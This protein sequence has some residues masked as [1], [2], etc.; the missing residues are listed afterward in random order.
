MKIKPIYTER[1]VL[2]GF[3]PGDAGFAISIWNDPEMGEYLP[4]PSIEHVD[5]EY[6]KSIENLGDDAECC[7]MIST[8]KTTA[9]RIGTCSFIPSDDGTV[10]DIAYC[11]HKTYW[12]QGF[13]TEMAKGMIDYAKQQGAKKITIDINRNNPASNKI[14]QK[15]GFIVIGEKTYTKKGTTLS[16]TDT[17]YE[18]TV[19]N[20]PDSI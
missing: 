12:N 10:Y 11:V 17:R 4:D 9:A 1:L 14:A 20:Q 15:L 13:A 8:L 16:Y 2:R 3:E 5:E 18:F 7:Y 19:S 6:R